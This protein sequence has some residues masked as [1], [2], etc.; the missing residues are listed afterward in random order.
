MYK[1][2]KWPLN[3]FMVHAHPYFQGGNP[4]IHDK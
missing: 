3:P 2:K 4:M 1:F